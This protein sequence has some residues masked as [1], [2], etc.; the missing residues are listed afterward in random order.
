MSRQLKF[1]QW[2]GKQFHYWGIGINCGDF[3]SSFTGPI[4]GGGISADNTDHG[5][6]TGLQDKNGK[7]IY[8]RDIIEHYAFDYSHKSGNCD[9]MVIW[10]DQGCCF[11]GPGLPSEWSECEVI[12]NIYENKDLI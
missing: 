3:I 5:Q 4:S 9:G 10:E 7:D 8:E 2:D 1:R 11:I 12:G 6:F